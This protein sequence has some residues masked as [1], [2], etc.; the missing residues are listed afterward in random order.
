MK[1][2]KSKTKKDKS[3]L[4]YYGFTKREQKKYPVITRK[5]EMMR[6]T[7]NT[8]KDLAKLERFNRTLQEE[9]L[10]IEEFTP[11][12]NLANQKLTE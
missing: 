8:P 7:G 3:L 11:D 1:E 9:H 4:S 2:V 6:Y 12:I 10:Q 5:M